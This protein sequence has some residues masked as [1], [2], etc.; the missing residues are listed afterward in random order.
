MRFRCSSDAYDFLHAPEQRG[1]RVAVG[2]AEGRVSVT[3]EGQLRLDLRWGGPH[4]GVGFDL[5]EMPDANTLIIKSAIKLG[6]QAA[7]YDIVYHRRI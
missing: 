5:F 2:G 1:V 7:T 4:G 6:E 3:A